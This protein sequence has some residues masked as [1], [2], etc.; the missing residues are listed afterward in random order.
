MRFAD[1]NKYPVAV[2]VFDVDILKAIALQAVGLYEGQTL[3][4]RLSGIG[5]QIGHF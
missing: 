2:E 1:A 3:V 4:G 5:T